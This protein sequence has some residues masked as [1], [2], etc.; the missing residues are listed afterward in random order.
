MTTQKLIYVF[1]L[2]G[3]LLKDFLYSFEYKISNNNPLYKEFEETILNAQYHNQWFTPENT[4]YALAQIAN[5]LNRDSLENWLNKYDVKTKN[6]TI[7]LIMAGNIPL[8]GFHDILSCLITQNKVIAKMSSQD[9][10]LPILL[11]RLITNIESSLDD[12]LFLTSDRI[13][14]FDAVIATGSNNSA[15]YFEYYFQKYPHIIRKNKTSI[16]ILDGNEPDNIIKLLAEDFFRYF[17]LGCRN[18]SKLYIPNNYDITKFKTLWSNFAN[19]INHNKYANNYIY[20]KTLYLM[21]NHP[22]FDAGYFIMVENSSIF[23]PISVLNYEFYSSEKELYKSLI[24]YK[25]DIQIIVSNNN[26]HNAFHKTIPIGNSQK[27]QLDD[28]ADGID[29]INF[30]LSL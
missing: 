6:K 5:N 29:T 8:V 21:N 14:H 9:N 22:F 30:I 11:K 18:I 10:I 13:T 26:N 19:L 16:A 20:N 24:P 17:G 3:D 1:S 4:T 15:R 25:N 27:P 28:Y 2:L 12:K 23:S 7:A